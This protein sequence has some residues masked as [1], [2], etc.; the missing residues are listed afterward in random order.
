MEAYNAE[1][2]V[3]QYRILK[4][5]YCSKKL[6]AMQCEKIFGLDK[7]QRS[8]KVLHDADLIH[9]DHA[10]SE[11]CYELT[12]LGTNTY[13]ILH[14]ERIKFW[15]ELLLSKWL[16]VVVAF[17]TAAITS[18]NWATISN[19]IVCLIHKCFN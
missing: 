12:T 3:E 17:I 6:S 4:R 2:T 16:D 14:E 9:H 7:Y 8:F 15:K 1:Y 13:F 19:W 18:A 10:T 5:L 11:E